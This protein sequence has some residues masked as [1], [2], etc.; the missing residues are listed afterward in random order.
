[1]GS[2][3]CIRDSGITFHYQSR[4]SNLFWKM[5]ERYFKQKFA[6]SFLYKDI[7]SWWELKGNAYEIDIVALCLEK[8]KAV[9]VEVKRQKKNYKPDLLEKKVERLKH[10]ILPHYMITKMCLSLEDM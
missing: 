7:G 9:A 10:K 1:M 8:D 3:M 4:L 2:E 6:E 5:L